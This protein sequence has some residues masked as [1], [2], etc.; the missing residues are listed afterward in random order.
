MTT[1]ILIQMIEQGLVLV[2]QFMTFW[3]TIRTDFSSTDQTAIDAALKAAQDKDA[4]DTAQEKLDAA[5]AG[6]KVD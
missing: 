3:E 5:A 4:A 2:P 6:G 1:A